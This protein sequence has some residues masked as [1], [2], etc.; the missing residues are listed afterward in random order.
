MV[1]LELI[2]VGLAVLVVSLTVIN[3]ARRERA[4]AVPSV[5]FVRLRQVRLRCKSCGGELADEVVARSADGECR[6]PSCFLSDLEAEARE[7]L[8]KDAEE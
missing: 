3:F 4:R 8:A 1:A 7:A 2:V 5:S 6:H